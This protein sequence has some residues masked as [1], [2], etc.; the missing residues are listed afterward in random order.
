[1][2]TQDLLLWE[3]VL[4]GAILLVSLAWPRPG[5][6]GFGRLLAWLDRLAR[7]PSLAALACAVLAFAGSALV[8]WLV[9]WP[10]P[11]IHDEFN[12]LLSADTFL[13]GRLSNPT[14]P[15]WEHFETFHVI[16]HPSYSTKFPP[17]SGL[18]IALGWAV[19]GHPLVG[20]WLSSALLCGAIAWML[21]GWLPPRWAVLGGLLAVA[22][23]GVASYWAQSFWGGAVAGAGGALVFGALPRI[24]R[25]GG[26]G[27]GAVLGAGLVLLATSRPFEGLVCALPTAALLALWLFRSRSVPL[28]GRLR[29]AAG[30]AAALALGLLFIGLHNRAVTGNPLR[31]PYEEHDEQYAVA[32]PFLWADEAPQPEYRL[33]LMREFWT[34]EILEEYEHQQR[35]GGWIE[36]LGKKM[37][38][39]WWFFLGPLPTFLLLA[40]PWAC[41]QRLRLFA[42]ASCLL[43]LAALLGETYRMAHYAAPGTAL[44]VIL[45][46]SCMRTL[47]AVRLRG[48][49]AGRS[50]MLGIALGIMGL[51]LAQ[52]ATRGA[53]PQAWF[54]QRPRILRA[55]EADEHRH[56][57]FVRY[58]PDHSVH[59]EWIYNAADIDAAE[60]VWARDLGPERNRRLVEHFGDR[61]AWFLFAEEGEGEARLA[62]Y[63][64][65]TQ[66]PFQDPSPR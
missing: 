64:S 1:M 3:C 22:Q 28:G 55:L 13:Q 21:F 2:G 44:L 15:F 58:G 62:A 42:F 20:I 40:L 50:A 53:D 59:D 5:A 32:P 7:R 52:A 45:V 8:A 46:M 29:A 24:L 61:K 19:G 57:V 38:L 26:A 48:R 56:L 47:S 27:L 54:R 30:T 11:R 63:E 39:L 31:L 49:R 25:G 23:Y 60:V 35:L 33:P 43:L 12:Y 9:F 10:E 37:P 14:H 41:R 36:G 6:R 51:G 17:G 4:L 65:V 18:L 34:G 66:T 16:H